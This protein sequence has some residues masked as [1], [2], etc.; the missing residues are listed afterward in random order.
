MS[1]EPLQICSCLQRALLVC[2][3]RCL[4]AP[5]IWL[6]K[7]ALHRMPASSATS[8][9]PPAIALSIRSEALPSEDHS[10]AATSPAESV[11]LTTSRRLAVRV[12]CLRLHDK[13]SNPLFHSIKTNAIR[14]FALSIPIDTSR[15]EQ[16]NACV[17]HYKPS[18]KQR[19]LQALRC[20]WTWMC[21]K[22]SVPP[23]AV[24]TCLHTS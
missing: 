11:A 13:P 22:T 19:I 18:S 24:F 7:L 20:R 4:H 6:P 8:G 2:R 10:T 9:R 17:V 14:Q 21:R 5:L 12:S 15:A 16:R 3:H 23:V 1:H